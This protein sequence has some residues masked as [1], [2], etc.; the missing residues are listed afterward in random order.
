MGELAG[1]ARIVSAIEEDVGGGLQFFET[2]GPHGRCDSM[3]ERFIRN[4]KAPVL[5]EA[6]SGEGIQS[7]LQLEAAGKAWGDFEDLAGSRFD[8]VSADAAASRRFLVYA[9]ELRW[10]DDG[11]TKG[12]GASENHFVGFRELF[13]E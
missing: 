13:S 6:R 7:V 3:R 10:L 12:L 2:A 5:Q 11:T 4:A 9:K 8:D 1:S